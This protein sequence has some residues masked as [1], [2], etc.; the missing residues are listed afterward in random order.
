MTAPQ[1]AAAST[2]NENSS[3]A[4]SCLPS[5]IVF[6]MTAQ[7]PAPNI[8]PIEPSIMINGHV[9]LTEANDVLPT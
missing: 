4:F 1:I 3:R 6:A 5:P 9:K 7:P 2:K 8:N